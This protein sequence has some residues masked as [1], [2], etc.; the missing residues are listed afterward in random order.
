VVAVSGGADSAALLRAVVELKRAA[1]GA[2]DLFVGHF[3][4][5]LRGRESEADAEWVAGLCHELGLRCEIGRADSDTG[6]V[7]AAHAEAAARN[8]RYE[9]LVKTAERLGARFVVTA[10]TADDQVE[11]VLHRL[12]R[13][14][15]LAGLAGMPAVR[16]LSASVSLVRP[17]LTIRRREIEDYLR[18][19]GQSYRTDSS[20]ADRQF[21]RN[22]IRHDLLPRLRTDFNPDV[23]DAI[24]RLARQAGDAQ[25]IV[26]AHADELLAECVHL[27]SPERLVI[28]LSA[29]GD[30]PPLVLRELCKR[31]WTQAG[32]PLQAM[33]F[34]E[35]DQLAELLV[36]ADGARSI[37]LPGGVRAV[38][39]GQQAILE[40]V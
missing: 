35:W 37:N 3:N 13:G 8:S 5:G 39:R 18:S 25:A 27:E 16:E 14:T 17:L 38:R 24:L 9:F 31:A 34:A 40:T 19:L 21:T 23:D 26:E 2:G 33:G 29:L 30:V 1:M 4:H 10:H 12:L 15:G 20:N 22:R 32:W 6:G 28:D 11:T 7:A 36:V